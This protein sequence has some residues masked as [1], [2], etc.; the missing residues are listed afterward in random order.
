MKSKTSAGFIPNFAAAGAKS[1]DRT[2]PCVGAKD[3][4]KKYGDKWMVEVVYDDLRDWNDW[5][6]RRRVLEP[7]GL[8]ALGS[9]NE[10]G[11]PPT[12]DGGNTMHQGLRVASIILPCTMAS[13]LT[14]RTHLMQLYD[15]GMS[16]MFVQEAYALAAAC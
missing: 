6:L 13:S 5:F 10:Q 16:S 4:Y 14:M 3:L 15:V 9:F 12:G 11:V 2:E 1:Q 7:E 8:I